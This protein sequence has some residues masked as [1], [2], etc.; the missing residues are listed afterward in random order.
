MIHKVQIL[1]V[2]NK[3]SDEGS[4]LISMQNIKLAVYY[5]APE[6]FI[7]EYLDN[8]PKEMEVDLWLVYGQGI[9]I[10]DQDE[11]QK[12]FPYHLQICGGNFKGT[13]VKV[14]SDDEYML[15]CGIHIDIADEG[16]FKFKVGD[17]IKTRGTYQIY[18]QGTKW[19][20]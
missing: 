1:E 4:L 13:I 6:K 16:D 3:E 2:L 8:L 18:F 9:V 14:L 19:T 12:V 11:F 20:R 7:S 10:E 5:Q 17:N 15:D